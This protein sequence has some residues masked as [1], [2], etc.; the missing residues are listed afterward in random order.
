MNTCTL[1]LPHTPTHNESNHRHPL[2]SLSFSH[3][4]NSQGSLGRSSF[5]CTDRLS[6]FGSTIYN[7]AQSIPSRATIALTPDFPS[8]CFSKQL[9]DEDS[10]I[11]AKLQEELLQALRTRQSNSSE[12]IFIFYFIAFFLMSGLDN[13]FT[14][15]NI[16]CLRKSS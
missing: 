3:D 6:I 5:S 11:P 9:G 16:L 13:I 1:I 4:S 12:K 10:I 8:F 2:C 7:T 14:H 15:V